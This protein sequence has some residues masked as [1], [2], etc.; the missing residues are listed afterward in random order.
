MDVFGRNIQFLRT[1]AACS[2]ADFARETSIDPD[3]LSLIEAGT[4]EPDLRQLLRIADQLNLS[5]DVLLR[6]DFAAWQTM[7]GDKDIRLILLDIDGTL[8]SGGMYYTEKGDQIKRFEVK[9]G[10]LIRRVARDYPVEFGFISSGTA[11]GIINAR[12]KD[13]GVT[14]I[15]AGPG[16]KSDIVTGWLKEMGIGYENLAYIGDDLNDL[17]VIEKAGISACPA[18]AVRQ[19][20]AAA[21]VVLR[22]NG[23]EGCVREFLE[24]VM[25]YEVDSYLPASKRN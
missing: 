22:K 25:G 8:T 24:E 19:V 1:R 10:I 6:R 18:D 7:I 17:S 4:A 9:D 16:V 2:I 23:G 12:A 21:D 20:K 15:F 11:R 14:R 3:S 5:V 13:L